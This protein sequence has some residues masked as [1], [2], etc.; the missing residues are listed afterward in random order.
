M[1]GVDLAVVGNGVLGSS[2][3]LE[4]ARRAP[5]LSI[6]VIGPPGRDGAA[7]GAAGAMLN[8][9]AEV[10]QYTS[11]HPAAEA[12]FAIARQAL[13]MWPDWLEMLADTA[14][15]AG[16]TARASHTT[17]TH[18]LLPAAAGP[19]A[20]RNFA[21]MRAGLD[22]HREPYEDLDL[23][24]L[25]AAPISGLMPRA[26]ALPTRAVHL[27]R[28]GAVDA[29]AVLDALTAAGAA[30]GVAF[31]P[32]TV[33]TVLATAGRVHGVRLA[34]GDVLDAGAVVLA[35]GSGSGELARDVLP[36]GAVPPMLHGTG[37]ALLTERAGP[38][39]GS[40]CV[41]RTPNQ[42]ATCGVH[43]VPHP[44]LG[45][46]YVG[47]TNFI[48]WRPWAG[49]GLGATE[50]LIRTV[51]QEIDHTIAFSTLR[52]WLWGVRPIPLDC[53]PLIGR[54]SVDGLLFATGTYRDGFHCS[55]LI[56]H[57]VAQT[58]LADEPADARFAWFRPERPPIQTMT[59]ERAISEAVVHGVETAHEQGL[60]LP[61]YLDDQ[62]LAG[63]V[64]DRAERF[65][66]A[67]PDPVALAP[68]I[69]L[70]A[71]IAETTDQETVDALAGYVRA[72]SA[73][74]QV[75]V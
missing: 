61:Y 16:A 43:V 65:Y 51:C 6:A 7:T 54:S 3:A 2:I 36:L 58:L 10:T 44:R 70:F 55:P 71:F 9:F 28:E 66:A 50:G 19:I 38:G 42:A 35:A 53:F 41:I 30:G 60:Q 8:C 46:Q 22:E 57:H 49:P 64:R 11:A 37:A 67:L 75:A 27:R 73:H 18:V 25:D 52:R 15:P 40:S 68:E 56:A 47:A 69:V 26:T 13:D 4:V 32:Q 48:T 14:G 21:A 23:S 1:R 20:V 72:A 17:G 29:R 45:Q 39:G 24:G 5:D 62:L 12:K 31:V 63:F 59:V 33:R 34:D 74:H